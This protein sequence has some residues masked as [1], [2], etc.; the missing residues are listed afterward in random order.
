MSDLN[1]LGRCCHVFLDTFPTVT[2]YAALESFAK[3]I[4]VFTRECKNLNAYRKNRIDELIFDTEEALVNALEIAADDKIYYDR[5]SVISKN[6]ISKFQTLNNYLNLWFH[7]FL[8]KKLLGFNIF[9]S[10]LDVP[11]S[12]IRSDHF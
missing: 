3:G 12:Q 2:G 8:I 9:I 4:P 7:I 10:F 11:G 6:F 5:L 1:I